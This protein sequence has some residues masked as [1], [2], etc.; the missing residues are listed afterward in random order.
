MSRFSVYLA[1]PISGLTY[2]GAEDWRAFA[3]AELAKYDIHGLS[4]LRAKE[5]LR[6]I[7]ALV[8][9]CAGYGELNCMSS[10]RGIMTRDRY[11]A[12]RCDVLLVNLLGSQRVSIGTVMEIAWADLCR[13]P[14]VVAMEPDGN[15][16]E[17]AMIAEAI[18]FRVASLEE[19]IH[20]VKAIADQ[21]RVGA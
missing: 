9:D 17:H 1:G 4:P 10:P 14:I 20:V 5:Y 7:P 3:K 21:E 16:H 8:A 11:D 2:D 15:V 19:A 18:G 13:T 6:G 12:T